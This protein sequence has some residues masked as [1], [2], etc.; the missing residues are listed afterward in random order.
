MFDSL[1]LCCYT[2]NMSISAF[3]F[4]GFGNGL[5]SLGGAF[6]ERAYNQ[7]IDPIQVRSGSDTGNDEAERCNLNPGARSLK[8]RV[9][10]LID[11]NKPGTALDI[12]QAKMAIA[13][14]EVEAIADEVLYEL[15][16]AGF[17]KDAQE[18][19]TILATADLEPAKPKASAEQALNAFSFG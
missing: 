19:K 3:A 8:E 12:L 13:P 11:N 10:T 5:P 4:D 16:E 15:E 6:N 7:A 14:E 1:F 2:R 9:L 18:F 17:E